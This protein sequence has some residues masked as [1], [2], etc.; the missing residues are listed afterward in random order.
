[1]DLQAAQLSGSLK[2][3]LQ[4][5]NEEGLLFPGRCFILQRPTAALDWSV[6]GRAVENGEM[7]EDLR[8]SLSE[9]GFTQV[10]K[11]TTSKT[12]S[13][14]VPSFIPIRATFW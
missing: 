3:L 1:M 10:K 12:K 14:V 2:E 6:L 5:I 13:S 7:E 8:L 4:K 9:N 11:A